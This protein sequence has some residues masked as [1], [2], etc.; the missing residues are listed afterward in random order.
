MVNID[1]DDKFKAFVKKE[2]NLEL[3]RQIWKLKDKIVADPEI[4]KPMR[5]GRKNKREAYL[6]SYRLSYSY[7]N[8]TITFLDIYHKDEQ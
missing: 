1:Y 3:K 2:K 5:Y 7:E 6:G 4:G 8:D